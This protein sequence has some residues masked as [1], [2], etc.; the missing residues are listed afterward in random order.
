MTVLPL[1]RQFTNPAITNPVEIAKV[2]TAEGVAVFRKRFQQLN[3]E[4]P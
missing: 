2:R 3:R 4:M 1:D